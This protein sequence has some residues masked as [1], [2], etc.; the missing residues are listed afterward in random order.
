MGRVIRYSRKILDALAGERRVDNVC[1]T[2]ITSNPKVNRLI[3]YVFGW[4]VL[5]QLTDH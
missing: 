2:L 3:G 5:R 1:L 4:G